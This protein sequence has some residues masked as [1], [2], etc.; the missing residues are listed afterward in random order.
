MTTAPFGLLNVASASCSVGSSDDDSFGILPRFAD[1]TDIYTVLNDGQ[2][3]PEVHN[4]RVAAIA[5]PDI[6]QSAAV[7]ADS[8]HPSKRAK[9]ESGGQLG[10]YCFIGKSEPILREGTFAMHAAAAA[11]A[12]AAAVLLL[13][14]GTPVA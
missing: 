6:R 11:A 9:L 4:T 7:A 8:D 3:K 2:A 14:C 13:Q 10:H 1:A 12:A 5:C